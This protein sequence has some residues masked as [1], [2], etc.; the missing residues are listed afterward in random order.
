MSRFVIVCYLLF[1]GV[2]WAQ[3]ENATVK[4][5]VKENKLEEVIVTSS[6]T[7]SRIENTPTRVEVLGLEE[8]NEENNIKPGN[9]MSLLG[10]IA[11]IQM[12]QMSASTG[13]TLARIQGLHGRYTQ[14][15][16]DGM[17]L[18]GGLSGNFGIM[19]I[20]PMDLK[21]IEI[22]KGSASTLYGG[23]A[24]GGIINLISKNPD[25]KRE[26]SFTANQTSLSETN[27]NGYF[28]KRNKKFGFTCFIG[29]TFQHHLD[30]DDDGLTDVAKVNN[31]VIHPKFIFYLSPAS[32]VTVNYS[33]TFDARKGGDNRYF[34]HYDSNLYHIVTQMQRHSLDAKWQYNLSE[35]SN[36]MFKTSSSFL[37]QKLDTKA[38][39]FSGKQTLLYA[40]ASY[41]HKSEKM[42][43]VAGIN[44]NGDFFT[45]NSSQILPLVSDYH[46]TTLGTFVQ[47]TYKPTKKWVLESGFRYDF[48]SK[49]GNFALPRLS[50][51]YKIN[52]DFST[53]LNG[54]FG[55]KSPVAL[56]YLDL[57]TDLAN[58]NNNNSLKAEW[59]RGWNADVNYK[60]RLGN[61]MS[62]T[63]N[64][65]FFYTLI[66]NPIYDSSATAGQ[67]ALQNASNSLV[68][69]GFQSYC[70]LEHDDFELYLG[71]VFTDVQKE[72]DTLHKSLTVTP[73]HNFSSTLFYEPS[74]TWRF[75][76]ESSLIAS[77][78]DQNY[79]PVKNYVL[80]AAM[81]QYKWSHFTMVLNIENLFDFKQSNYGKIYSGTIDN[82]KFDKLWAPIDGR[83]FNFSIKY[84]LQQ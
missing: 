26:L 17:P 68:T 29:Q 70:R 37:D 3:N 1:S 53:R 57:E 55:Y 74:E 64:Q 71:Y 81:L 79:Q 22:I 67:T 8:M 39:V 19:Q 73:K 44:C 66:K 36:L 34:A 30:I 63:F 83:V 80:A 2:L 75:G 60:K 82:P 18:Y 58:T 13:N 46:N 27:L 61:N 45:D 7:N 24:I 21:Q 47:N 65:S 51:L 59:S 54:G 77:Q 52:A 12:Q 11:G 31:T 35:K 23:D 72:Y 5:S 84:S 14:L 28:S 33:A 42:D 40:E 10:D 15:L 69:R 9:I 32:T 41:F 49:Y 20:P 78:L 50:L 38:Y 4:D 16:K 43:W 48:N 76:L 62:I 25:F 6:R 56:N